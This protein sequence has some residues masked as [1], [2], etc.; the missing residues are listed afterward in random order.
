[1]RNREKGKKQEDKNKVGGTMKNGGELF[2]R[3]A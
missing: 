2:L 3:R 1:M